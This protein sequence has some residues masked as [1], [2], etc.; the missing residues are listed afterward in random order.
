[1]GWFLVAAQFLLLGVLIFG[2]SG[3]AWTVSG[4]LALVGLLLRGVGLVVI[5]GACINLGRSLSPHPQPP[6]EAVLRTGG[7]YRHVRHPLYSGILLLAAGIA[8]TSGSVLSL[9]V[10]VLLAMVLSVKARLEERLLRERFPGYEEYARR[11]AAFFPKP[12]GL[13]P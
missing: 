2:L 11:T 3:D 8:L 6:A 12:G 10:L 13:F 1:M 9:A 5:V 4:L 7:L